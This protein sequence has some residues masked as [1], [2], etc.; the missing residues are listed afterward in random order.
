LKKR[1]LVEIHTPGWGRRNVQLF[2]RAEVGGDEA[3]SEGDDEREDLLSVDPDSRTMKWWRMN[4]PRSGPEF[5]HPEEKKAQAPKISRTR[6]QAQGTHAML[7]ELCEFRVGDEIM[8]AADSDWWC[9]EVLEVEAERLYVK[10][11]HGDDGNLRYIE[12]TKP[13]AKPP[14]GHRLL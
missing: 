2:E 8:A 11:R 5:Y 14:G 3:R 4:A 1:N 13:P 9:S 10:I 6:K 12:Y 7:P